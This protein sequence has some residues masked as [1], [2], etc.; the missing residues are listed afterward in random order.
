MTTVEFI[1]EGTQLTCSVC[2]TKI[3]KVHLYYLTY[4]HTHRTFFDW[5]KDQR[6]IEFYDAVE[7]K[8]CKCGEYYLKVTHKPLRQSF[9]TEKGWLELR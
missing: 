2:N 9:Y 6:K 4:I 3:C 5:A 1:P 8:K 7:S